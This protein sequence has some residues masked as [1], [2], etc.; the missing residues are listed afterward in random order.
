M[1]KNIFICLSA[2][3]LFCLG[4]NPVFSQAPQTQWLWGEVSSVDLGNK[5][6]SV[7]Y[8]DYE[9][10]QEKVMVLSVNESTVYENAKSLDEIK[11]QDAVSV[12]YSVSPDGKSVALKISLEKPENTPLPTSEMP[13]ISPTQAPA[14]Q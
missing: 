4:I 6:V 3:Y 10:D 9:Q 1:R 13:D 11:S 14:G 7:K 8:L 2:V 12:D 5:T